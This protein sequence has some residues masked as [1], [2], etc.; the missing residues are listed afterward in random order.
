MRRRP[1]RSSTANKKAVEAS[2]NLIRQNSATV[3]GL[4]FASSNT[5]FLLDEKKTRF[6][7]RPSVV[8]KPD[9]QTVMFDYS[10]V[11]GDEASIFDGFFRGL[12]AG[13][14][15]TLDGGIESTCNFINEVTGVP[16]TN[17]ADTYTISTV[18]VSK[19]ILVATKGTSISSTTASVFDGRYFIDLPQWTKTQTNEDS[20]TI[21]KILNL[22]PSQ[23]I[24]HLGVVPGSVLEFAKTSKNNSRF[25]VESIYI[26]NGIECI[27]V[28]E[29]VV[30]EDA[31][32]EQVIVSVYGEEPPLSGQ[33][34]T[35][36]PVL[37]AP[38]LTTTGNRLNSC[39]TGNCYTCLLNSIRRAESNAEGR[40]GC[41]APC[42]GVGGTDCGPYQI[43]CAAYVKDI[44]ASCRPG[45]LIEDGRGGFRRPRQNEIPT[46]C[47]DT[48]ETDPQR[49][50]DTGSD[51]KRYCCV[52][53]PCGD[54][55][56]GFPNPDGLGRG[57]YDSSCCE[58]CEANYCSK[59][60]TACPP[61]PAGAACCAEKKRA[62]EKLIECFNR[63]YLRNPNSR[64]LCTGTTIHQYG[65]GDL[66]CCT[67]EDIARR[68][69]RGPRKACDSLGEH[70]WEKDPNGVRYWM[71]Q[72]CPDCLPEEDQPPVQPRPGRR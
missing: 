9:R 42:T 28:T 62:S 30:Q 61:G 53:S 68:H 67:C 5:D 55:G 39:C 63:R 24:S 4:Y 57:C 41:D 48:D 64:C 70:Y 8:V 38:I 36:P 25:T 27:D 1:K 71:R 35:D 66:R 60:T 15:L 10:Q 65:D 14:T 54:C 37:P 21:S 13:A 7:L 18:D 12:S 50:N 59:L 11:T 43:N 19:K 2:D 23:S 40:E 16:L 32:E 44:C 72:E 22:L 31:S 3:Y 6:S 17:F 69:N 29:Q 58:V 52:S 20:T 56:A 34:S 45:N 49:T 26:Q 46:R 51:G 33:N 47:G